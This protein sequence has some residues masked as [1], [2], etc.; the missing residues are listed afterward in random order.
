[1]GEIMTAA[2]SLDDIN[3]AILKMRDGSLTGRWLTK[4]AGQ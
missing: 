3:T 4:M 1:M 2:H